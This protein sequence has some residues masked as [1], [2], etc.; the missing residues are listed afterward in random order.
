M[1]RL[2]IS[3][4]P[5]LRKYDLHNIN[6]KRA[7]WF[8]T[9]P[10]ERCITFVFQESEKTQWIKCQIT[11]TNDSANRHTQSISGLETLFS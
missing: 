4:D 9:F 11:K 2:L 1:K 5:N 8:Q 10:Q 3:F 6:P 7:F